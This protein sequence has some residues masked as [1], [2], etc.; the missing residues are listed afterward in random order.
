MTYSDIIINVPE[1]KYNKARCIA[2]STMC[3]GIDPDIDLSCWKFLFRCCQNYPSFSLP[4]VV[5]KPYS[6]LSYIKYHFIKTEPG[7]MYIVKSVK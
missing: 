5:T 3:L 1:H 4:Y 7:E 2:C 6:Y